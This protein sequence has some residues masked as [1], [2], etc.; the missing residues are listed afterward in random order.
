MDPVD[1]CGASAT[2]AG[3]SGIPLGGNSFFCRHCACRP[4]PDCCQLGARWSK[5]ASTHEKDGHTLQRHALSVGN[6]DEREDGRGQA[7]GGEEVE[8]A[9]LELGLELRSGHGGREGREPLAARCEG[10]GQGAEADGEHLGGDNPREAVTA[11]GPHPAVSGAKVG[12]VGDSQTVEE[13]EEH[14]RV[15]ASL[16]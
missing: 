7:D 8:Q 11:K 13:E 3:N 9:V 10:A 5:L 16:S 2:S 1:L 4:L 14:R 12:E 15:A 6:P